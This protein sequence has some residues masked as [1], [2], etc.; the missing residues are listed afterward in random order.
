AMTGSWSESFDKS[1]YNLPSSSVP[2]SVSISNGREW[3]KSTTPSCLPPEKGSLE[4]SCCPAT[5]GGGQRICSNPAS[6]AP[7]HIIPRLAKSLRVS[8]VL[9]SQPTHSKHFSLS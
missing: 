4:R 9:I 5:L 2:C 3:T 7:A 1:V 6:H 8:I